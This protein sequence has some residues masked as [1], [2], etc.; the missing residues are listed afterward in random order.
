MSY[1]QIFPILGTADIRRLVSFY[2]TA[3]DAVV[4]YQFPAEGDPGFV[5]LDLAGGH[6]GIGLDPAAPG[7]DTA[8]RTALW[9]YA[10]DC[11]EAF[12][13][14]VEAGANALEE[15]TDM[16]WGERVAKVTDPDGNIVHIGQAPAGA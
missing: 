6:L 11:D 4:T 14:L 3:V 1:R 9:L 2:V 5:S 10:D 15:P 12:R 16:P 7:S 8:Q 13:R